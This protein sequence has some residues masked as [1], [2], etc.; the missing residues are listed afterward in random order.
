MAKNNDGVFKHR[1]G[2]FERKSGPRGFQVVRAQSVSFPQPLRLVHAEYTVKLTLKGRGA[3]VHYRGTT[4]GGCTAGSITV[5]EPFEPIASDVSST[6]TDF[7]TLLIDPRLVHE[8]LDQIRPSA[9]LQLAGPH[10]S[11]ALLA[12]EMS[13]IAREIASGVELTAQED[14]VYTA[15]S[16]LL[17]LRG[18]D[19]AVLAA[20]SLHRAREVILDRLTENVPI[21]EM[22]RACGLSRFHLIRMFR[23]RFGMP[24][25]EFRTHARVATAR[26]L[27]AQGH[28]QADVAI[29]VG[30]F[31]QSHLHR[32]FRRLVGIS[33]GAFQSCFQK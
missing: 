12:N 30:F 24:P 9:N 11:H 1:S 19:R 15:L 14:R 7:L 22:E 32:H 4:Y 26:R 29:K 33:P 25:H 13:M 27:L 20:D 10:V 8:A 31:D 21:D 18:M 5:F 16:L 23:K 2:I 28:S 6:K 3:P 17:D